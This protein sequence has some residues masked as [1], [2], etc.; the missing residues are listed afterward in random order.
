[1]RPVPWSRKAALAWALGLL[2]GCG[3]P[4][5][6]PEPKAKVAPAPP[7][8]QRVRFPAA[9]QTSMKLEPDHL[10]GKSFLPGG[11]LAE[12]QAKKTHYQQFLIKASD[13]QA[14]A[15]ML[16]DYKNAMADA[17]YLAHMGGYFGQ[18]NGQPVYVFAKGPWLAGFV[19]LPEKEAD[20]LAREFAARLY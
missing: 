7:A 19:G 9:N 16:L 15:I 18:D 12:Y 1:M 4:A 10:L 13:A 14:A 11:N 6:A 2:A 8:D 17:K 5:P 3:G 20:P